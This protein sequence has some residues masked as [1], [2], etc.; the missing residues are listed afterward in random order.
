[1]AASRSASGNSPARQASRLPVADGLQRPQERGKRR[2]STPA[3][4]PAGPPPA[5]AGC[6]PRSPAAAPRV[7]EPGRAPARRSRAGGRH[8]L[9]AGPR[10]PARVRRSTSSARTTRTRSF[11]AIRPAASGSMA[12]QPA[13]Q[14]RVAA[15]RGHALQPAGAARDRARDPRTGRAARPSGTAPCPPRPA[16]AGP[17]SGSPPGPPGPARRSPRPRTAGPG[18]PRRSDGGGRGPARPRWAWRCRCRGPRYT[19]RLSQETISPSQAAASSRASAL[20]PEAVGPHSAISAGVEQPPRREQERQ[21]DQPEQDGG[22]PHL[23]GVG[24][25]ARP[26]RRAG[27]G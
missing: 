5:S 20:L 18:P 23:L 10:S 14:E 21:Q 4:R 11:G 6:G 2:S 15:P 17:G 24:D 22:A 8:R 7:P 12:R 25:Q 3:P 19:C 1:M 9:V 26:S 16:A 13:V 27:R